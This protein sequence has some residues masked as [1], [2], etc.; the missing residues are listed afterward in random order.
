MKPKR[1]APSGSPLSLPVDIGSFLFLHVTLLLY[2]VASVFAKYAGLYRL[3]GLPTETLVF[4]G[5]EFLALLVY[6]LLWQLSLRR[7]PLSFAY[8]N[9]AVCTLWT[10]LF[11]LVFFREALTWG[12][13]AGALAVLAGVI[14]VVTDHDA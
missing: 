14:L 11:G 4:V 2:S 9:K 8:S 6:T 10:I 5:L 1:P 12:K 3:A 7:V 13:A